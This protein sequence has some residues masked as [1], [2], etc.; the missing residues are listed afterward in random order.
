M[1]TDNEYNGIQAQ[2]S[3]IDSVA[4]GNNPC[5]DRESKCPRGKLHCYNWLEDVPGGYA[6]FDMVEVQFKTLLLSK[7]LLDTILAP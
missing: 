7:R 4:T 3:E 5:Y 2:E 6:D 1:A